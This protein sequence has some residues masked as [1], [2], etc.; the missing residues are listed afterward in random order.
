MCA[1]YLNRGQRDTK[2]VEQLAAITAHGSH[3]LIAFD[4]VPVLLQKCV[5]VVTKE[6]YYSVK[7]DLL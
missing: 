1:P 6:T 4:A 2:L 5:S 7:R 3:V